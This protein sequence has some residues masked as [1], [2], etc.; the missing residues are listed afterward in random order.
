MSATYMSARAAANRSIHQVRRVLRHERL[1]RAANR[2][3]VL[4]ERSCPAR[5][6]CSD[7][8]VPDGRK[9]ATT[10][11]RDAEFLRGHDGRV[12]PVPH[13]DV[14]LVVG[15]RSAPRRDRA[16]RPPS[17]GAGF[18]GQSATPSSDHRSGSGRDR[19]PRRRG[20]RHDALRSPAAHFA[21]GS[22]DSSFS[23][24]VPTDRHIRHDLRRSVVLVIRLAL[25]HEQVGGFVAPATAPNSR[26]AIR[27]APAAPTT[28]RRKSARHCRPDRRS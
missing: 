23:P 4:V 12:V 2:R 26:S 25:H 9:I 13:V 7:D 3:D 19:H 21:V 17:A 27:R 16:P 14:R 1:R 11:G 18:T 28:P 22:S 15:G 20:E 10:V 24:G 8:D 5:R 6:A